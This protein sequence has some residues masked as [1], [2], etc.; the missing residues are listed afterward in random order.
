MLVKSLHDFRGKAEVGFA[1]GGKELREWV[2]RSEGVLAG[3]EKN[4]DT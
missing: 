1:Y 2:T 3:E 4:T